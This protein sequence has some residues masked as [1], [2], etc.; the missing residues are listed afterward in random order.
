MTARHLPRFLHVLTT[1]HA[2]GALACFIMAIGSSLSDEFREAL[3]VSGGSRVMVDTFGQWTWLFLGLVGLILSVLAWASWRLR[4]WAW[5]LTL[6][7]YGVGVIG[8][9][10]QVSIGI[11]QGWV[12]AIVNGAVFSYAATPAVRHA[13]RARG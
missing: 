11:P 12:A 6:V 5:E 3:A 8:S 1:V 7:V 2:V 9:L 10:W 13:Y 4:P